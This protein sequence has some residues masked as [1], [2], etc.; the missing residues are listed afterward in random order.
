MGCQTGHWPGQFGDLL[1]PI[2]PLAWATD[3]RR[4]GGRAPGSKDG[5][6][7]DTIGIT[8]CYA[9]LVLLATGCSATRRGATQ[10]IDIINMSTTQSHNMRLL[11]CA[12]YLYLCH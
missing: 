10:N 9:L 2:G 7:D 1:V 8:I 6:G 3:W 4:L 11:G 5:G 12:E